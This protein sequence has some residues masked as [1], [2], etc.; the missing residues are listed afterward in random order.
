MCGRYSLHA[1]PQVVALQFGLASVADFQPRYNI[2]PAATVLVV[3]RGGAA[4]AR[5]QLGGKYH[6]LRADSVM[7]KPFWREAYRERRCLIPASGFYEWQREPGAKQP[8]YIRP[9]GEPLFAFAGIWE[10]WRG[11]E[12]CAIVTT[13]ANDV[14]RRIHDRM[15]VIVARDDYAGW[16]GG[17]EGLLR[18]APSEAIAVSAVER[19]GT[20]GELFGD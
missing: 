6:N 15:P 19:P 4:L 1:S 5:W 8:Y 14:V 2:A 3:R 9:L 18:P 20:T 7:R 17:G 13:E 16:L 11:I 12:S 10:R